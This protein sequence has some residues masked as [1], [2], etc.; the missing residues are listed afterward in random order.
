MFRR[1]I[2]TVIGAVFLGWSAGYAADY[3]T[4]EESIAIALQNN[5]QIKAQ[6]ENVRGRLMEKRQSLANLLPLVSL[7][8]SYTRY[9]QAPFIPLPPMAIPPSTTSLFPDEIQ[10][11]FRNN[12]A[13]S[14]QATQPLFTGGALYNAYKVAG[15]TYQATDLTRSQT[16]RDLKRLVIE[17]YY[18]LIQARQTL[19]VARSSMVSLKSHLDV[20]N[21]FYN[22]GM[23]PKNDLLQSQVSYAQSQQ[24]V[25]Q[26]DNAA[27]IAES[28]LNEIM[29]RDL[30]TPIATEKEIPMPPLN[31]TVDQATE[32]A[33]ANRQEIRVTQLQLDSA[34]KG[35]T[36]AR[37][38]YF[39]SLAATAAY[40]KIGEQPDVDFL[41]SWS[42]GVGAT[43][44][45]FQGGFTTADVSRATADRNRVL[46]QLQAQKNRVAL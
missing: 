15:N 10:T 5:P 46:Y 11:G 25:I 39:P 4:L 8:Y 40:D 34:N 21:A 22:Q 36:I 45:I 17:G 28:N 41:D 33:F 43:W 30:A 32:T 7:N 20:A 38:G 18:R 24:Y 3:L 27:R 29:N 31:E 2:V 44:Y 23:I 16:I 1:I 14:V 6:N 37:A 9:N 35:I 12:Y 26:A 13:F 19:D 42:L